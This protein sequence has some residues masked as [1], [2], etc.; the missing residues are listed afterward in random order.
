MDSTIAAHE[1]YYQQRQLV[2]FFTARDARNAL[3]HSLPRLSIG[4]CDPRAVA[5]GVYVLSRNGVV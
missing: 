4:A 5:K 3:L 2:D 1:R